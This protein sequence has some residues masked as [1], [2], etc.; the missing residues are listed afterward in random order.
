MLFSPVDFFTS[1]WYLELFFSLL[2]CLI[3]K[4]LV[5]M[6]GIWLN[7][8]SAKTVVGATVCCSTS[9]FLFKL[10]NTTQAAILESHD[11]LYPP[12]SRLTRIIVTCSLYI[13]T[14]PAIFML[15][16]DKFCCSS[17]GVFACHRLN[18]SYISFAN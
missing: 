17:V 10:I 3:C 8:M 5:C 18:T 13:D 9:T 14:W 16:I 11:L 4:S 15:F 1:C 6:L 7:N 2:P 12:V